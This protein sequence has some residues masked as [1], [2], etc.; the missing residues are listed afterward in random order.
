M[1]EIEYQFSFLV[2]FDCELFDV[3]FYERIVFYYFRLS[4]REKVLSF[5]VIFPVLVEVLLRV[6][7]LRV[8]SY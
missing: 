1:I 8:P 5:R 7:E 2:K 6:D 3:F 4:L